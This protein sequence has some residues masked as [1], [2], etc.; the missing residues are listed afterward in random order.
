MVCSVDGGG[1]KE[2]WKT[3]WKE[4]RRDAICS[5]N[6]VSSGA[7]AKLYLAKSVYN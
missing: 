5:D 4:E 7:I 3:V 2:G 6:K 1:G